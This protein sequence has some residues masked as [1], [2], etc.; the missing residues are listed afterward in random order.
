MKRP[1]YLLY[2]LRPLRR[3][4]HRPPPGSAP[5]LVQ[6]STPEDVPPPTITVLAYGADRATEMPIEDLET[7]RRMRGTFPVLWVNVDGVE[8]IDTVRDLGAVFGLHRLALEDVVNVPQ[9]AKVEDYGEYLFIVAHMARIGEGLSLNLEQIGIFLGPDFVLTFQER[10]GDP[11]D[12]VRDRIRSKVGRIRSAGADYLAYAVL[13]AV[14][15]HYF[16]VLERLGECIDEVEDQILGTS[17]R[18]LM[19]RL[20]SIKRELTALRRAIWPARDALNT[21]LRDPHPVIDPETQ[22]Y[23]RDCYDHVVQSIDLVESYRDLTSSLTDLYLSTLGNRTNEIMKVLTIFSA[24][25]IPLTFIAGVY[26]MNFDYGASPLNM[27][28]LHWAWGYPFALL[29]MVVVALLML[30][31]FRRRGWLG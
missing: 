25:F 31:F 12:P 28:E 13:D 26:G 5:G 7:L 17:D 21:L 16:P 27:P 23:L 14:V 4:H 2:P 10:A 9:R 15:D 8:H 22:V 29:L 6:R 11:L 30:F 19:A 1:N 20:Y 24:I 18:N 3:K